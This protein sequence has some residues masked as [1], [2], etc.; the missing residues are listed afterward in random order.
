MSS[1]ADA[2]HPALTDFDISKSENDHIT[3]Y[4]TANVGT[5][6]YMAPELQ[7]NPKPTPQCDVYSLGV[8][9]LEMFIYDCKDAQ[10]GDWQERR[11]L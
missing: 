8:T 11:L 1:N 2:A 10:L 3:G 7:A 9:F 5:I 6:R 4:T